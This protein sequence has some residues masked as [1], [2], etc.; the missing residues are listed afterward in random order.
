MVKTVLITG[1]NRGIGLAFAEHYTKAGWQVIATAR[2]V[3]GADK[4]SESILSTFIYIIL[5]S[6]NIYIYK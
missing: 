1:A 2:N 5:S 6:V 4:V 3:N